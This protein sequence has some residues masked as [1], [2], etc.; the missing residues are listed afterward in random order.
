MMLLFLVELVQCVLQGSFYNFALIS[1]A[2]MALAFLKKLKVS[3]F[4]KKLK[5]VES[6]KFVY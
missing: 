6:L 5:G 2:V 1:N 4:L 3:D